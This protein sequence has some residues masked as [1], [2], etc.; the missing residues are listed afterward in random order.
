M[1]RQRRSIAVH[2][3]VGMAVGA[4]VGPI[5]GFLAGVVIAGIQSLCEPSPGVRCRYDGVYLAIVTVWLGVIVGPV[6][7]G[8]IFGMRR[9]RRGQL[10]VSG[11]PDHP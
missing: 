5:L 1:A 2:V 3:L 4:V 7:F 11:S 8:G 10:D 6:L 9:W